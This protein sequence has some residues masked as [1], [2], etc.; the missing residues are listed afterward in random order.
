MTTD[1][2]RALSGAQKTPK[3]GLQADR[4]YTR[5]MDILQRGSPDDPARVVASEAA[6]NKCL[7]TFCFAD[8]RDAL[9]WSRFRDSGIVGVSKTFLLP[10]ADGAC[11][12]LFS[13]VAAP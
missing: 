13:C 3:M 7:T 8:V 11:R 1:N 5:I 10:E 12:T 4:V 6:K 2:V 9:A